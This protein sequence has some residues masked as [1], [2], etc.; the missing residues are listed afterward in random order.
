MIKHIMGNAQPITHG[1]RIANIAARTATARPING[2]AMIIKLQRNANG[3]G[4]RLRGQLEVAGE[5]VGVEVGLDDQLD[6]HAEFCGVGQ[7]LR[8]VA[9]GVDHH[10]AAGVLVAEQVRRH[11]ETPQV[12]RLLSLY[13]DDMA[14]AA[15]TVSMVG[16]GSLSNSRSLI[17]E[18]PG[19]ALMGA[20]AVWGR[21]LSADE[22][23]REKQL[24]HE[25]SLKSEGQGD[26][27]AG[28]SGPLLTWLAWLAVGIPLA[29]GIWVTLQKSAVLFK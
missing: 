6:R 23:A 22:L 24:A 3:F 1:A 10:G 27:Q 16:V 7:V 12:G 17:S 26:I 20:A 11:Q 15:A 14:S 9:L 29:Y 19:P 18:P 13:V 25:K 21:V 28:H 8:H 5:E 4:A 2:R